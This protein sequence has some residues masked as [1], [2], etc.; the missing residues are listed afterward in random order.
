MK[1][2]QEGL[3][4][5][6]H[7]GA[8]EGRKYWAGQLS[9]IVLTFI[10]TRPLQTL[11]QILIRPTPTAPLHALLKNVDIGDPLLN[12]QTLSSIEIKAMYIVQAHHKL[13]KL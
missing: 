13:S 5:E 7:G 12:N 8:A 4:Q 2:C 6:M 11:A 9:L 1:G 10:Q 3:K